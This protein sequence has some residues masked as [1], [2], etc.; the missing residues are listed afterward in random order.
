[1]RDDSGGQLEGKESDQIALCKIENCDAYDTKILTNIRVHIRN[2]MFK[3]LVK[4]LVIKCMNHYLNR[5][6]SFD[7]LMRYVCTSY[8][9]S[10]SVSA[11]SFFLLS[12]FSYH[13]KNQNHVS[14][15]L[16]L[17]YEVLISSLIFSFLLFFLLLSV[18]S[19]V[20]TKCLFFS[21]S[22]CSFF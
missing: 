12:F 20:H 7:I 3:S 15:L 8:I 6:V 9:L 11:S 19:V 10:F 14:I 16:F 4:R 17:L 1:M 22:L 2:C 5:N 21:S 18:S 13:S